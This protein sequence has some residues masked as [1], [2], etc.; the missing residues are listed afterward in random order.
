MDVCL[1]GA[2]ASRSWKRAFCFFVHGGMDEGGD[3][4]EKYIQKGPEYAAHSS[5]LNKYKS[6][7][8]FCHLTLCIQIYRHVY[9]QHFPQSVFLVTSGLH[10]KGEPKKSHATPQPFPPT[11][12]ARRHT[13]THAPPY[14]TWI[15]FCF[16]PLNPCLRV[17]CIC[18]CHILQWKCWIKMSLSNPPPP[19]Q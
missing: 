7:R 19:P 1:W 15:C 17:K 13:H 9:M 12:P 6:T 16:S 4:I 2:Q 11:P 18:H 3:T 5:L 14:V 8:T 10:R